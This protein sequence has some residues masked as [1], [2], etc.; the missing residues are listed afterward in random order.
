MIDPV[1]FGK[2]MV[3]LF[4]KALEPIVAD[5]KELKQKTE[6]FEIDEEQLAQIVSREIKKH[7]EANPIKGEKGDPGRDG[8][9]IKDFFRAEGDCLV[10][11]M[12]DGTVKNL[13]KYIGADGKDGTNG[14]DGI[15]MP[16]ITREYDPETH[17]IVERWEFGGVTKELRYAAGG[18]YH[19][20]Y[21]REGVKCL[22]GR[23]WTHGGT[24]WIA[25]RETTEKPS[26]DSND[27]EIFASKG[28][29]GKDGRDGKIITPIKL[30]EP[31]A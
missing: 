6:N 7:I 8:L 20:G 12:T 24:V 14:K 18:I 29:D 26:R 4:K 21:W 15:G 5:I 30:G 9:D 27:W 10:A 28:R 22:A 2:K 25:K 11:V 13:G 23:T 16:D 31:D 19:G 3:E 17:A 1:E